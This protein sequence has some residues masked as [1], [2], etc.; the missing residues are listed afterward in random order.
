[1]DVVYIDGDPNNDLHSGKTCGRDDTCGFKQSDGTPGSN[2]AAIRRVSGYN[3]IVNQSGS[4]VI[5]GVTN[6]TGVA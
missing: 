5:G 2:G 1:M 3:V 4:G 6:A